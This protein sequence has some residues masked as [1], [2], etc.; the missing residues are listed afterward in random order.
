MNIL[1]LDNGQPFTLE[2]PYI[3]PLGGAETSF[4]LLAK[5]LEELGYSVVLL[6]SATVGIPQQQGNLLIHNI[7][8]WQRVYS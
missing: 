4:L 2:T 3:Q 5:G 7:N 6:T 8:N 1:L